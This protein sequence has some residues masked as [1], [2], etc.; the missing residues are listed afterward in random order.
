MDSYHDSIGGC[1]GSPNG[2]DSIMK[3][4]TEADIRSI[5]AVM[6]L[7]PEPGLWR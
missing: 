3:G 2:P 4:L 1:A 6:R 5:T 7:V